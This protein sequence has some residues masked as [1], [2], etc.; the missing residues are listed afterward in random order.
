[1]AKTAKGVRPSGKGLYVDSPNQAKRVNSFSS[2]TDMGQEKLLELGNKETSEKTTDL[3]NTVSLEFNNYGS[4][5]PFAM[6][7]GQGLW[8]GEDNLNRSVSDSDFDNAIVDVIVL[9]SNDDASIDYAEYNSYC[10]LNSFSISYPADGVSTHTFDFEGSHTR[11]FLN[12]WKNASVYKADFVNSTTAIISGANIE[13]T[14]NPILLLVNQNIVSEI[15]D[16]NDSITLTDAASD[17]NIVATD[18]DGSIA[19]ASGDRIRI[20]VSGTGSTYTTLPNTPAGIGGLRRGHVVA[21]IYNPAGNAE[22]TLRIQSLS[23]DGDLGREELQEIGSKRP[24]DRRLTRPINISISVDITDTDLEEFAKLAGQETA[25]DANTL[26]EIDF[27]D[28]LRNSVIEILEYKDE[29]AH[30]FANE[31][32]RIKITNV[33]FESDS[34]SASAGDTVASRTLNLSAENITISGSGVSPFL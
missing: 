5:A 11:K 12:D 13:A 32:R 31:L 25:Y 34:D 23:I 19:F 8:A 7:L 10:F 1:M 3:S 28:M 30:T 2:D 22:N 33:S 27:E 6:S 29:F 17:T 14:H 24:Y 18:V 9:A 26:R 15:S 21:R 16:S 4:M 20:V